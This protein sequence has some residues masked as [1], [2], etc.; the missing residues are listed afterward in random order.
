VYNVCSSEFDF[1]IEEPG[2]YELSYSISIGNSFADTT[3]QVE[4]YEPSPA[5]AVTYDPIF[6]ELVCSNCFDN[7]LTW[8][9]D[10]AIVNQSSSNTFNAEVDGITQNGTYQL[11]TTNSFGC[12]TLSDTVAVCQPHLAASAT[13]G[14]A[15]ITVYFNNLTDTI[16]GMTCSLNTGIALVEDFSSQQQV[17]YDIPGIY[18]VTITCSTSD[19]SGTYT[20]AIEASDVQTP[21]LEIDEINETVVC[22]NASVFTDFLW[23]IDGDIIEGGSSQAL[24]G[25]VY[26]LQ[27]YNA[28]GCGGASLL[29]VNNVSEISNF[30]IQAY[31]NPANE[32]IQILAEGAGWITIFNSAGM[33]VFESSNF[34]S[35]Q[36]I[37]TQNWP[38][39]LY[40][41]RWKSES[42]TEISKFEI[43]H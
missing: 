13:V 21:E 7:S 22:T 31:P 34:T 24:G 6:H 23:N 26:Q 4:V 43:S 17:T 29:I 12:N 28:I 33:I 11:M 8:F 36:H 32:S 10:G 37:A 5:P 18:N 39:G 2:I 3:L 40:F 41:A 16:S 35:Q 19:A 20:I 38:A 30:G 27:A 25:D 15:P 9:F 14:C 42:S 1:V